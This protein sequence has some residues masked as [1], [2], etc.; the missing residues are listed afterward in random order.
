M[1]ILV[2]FQIF[3]IMNHATM[4]IP[5]QVFLWAYIFLSLVYI[6]KGEMTGLGVILYLTFENLPNYFPL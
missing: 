5:V 6:S 3:V 4:N 2:C 1:D